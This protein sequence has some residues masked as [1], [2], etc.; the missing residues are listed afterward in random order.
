MKSEFFWVHEKDRTIVVLI[1][2]N[3]VYQAQSEIY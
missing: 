1:K 3:I 2:G